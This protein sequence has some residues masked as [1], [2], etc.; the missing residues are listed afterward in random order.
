MSDTS[1]TAVFAGGCFW[2]MEPPY[3]T[4]PGVLS[5]VSGYTGGQMDNPT[6]EQVSSGRSGH[7]E[8]LQVTFDPAKVSYEELLNVFWQNIDPLNPDGQFCDRGEQYRSAVFVSNEEEQAAAESSRKKV[9]ALL[10]R[11][12]ATEILDASIFYPA[13]DYH[14]DYYKENPTRYKFYRW[15]CGRDKRLEELWGKHQPLN[16]F[17]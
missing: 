17:E 6:Y 11:T 7:L 13:E 5:T 10:G 16:L 4:L 15:N 14:Q 3:D 12:V 1:R 2:C 9:E 8:V